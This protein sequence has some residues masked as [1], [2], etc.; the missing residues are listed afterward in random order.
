[1][2]TERVAIQKDSDLTI[3]DDVM[4]EQGKKLKEEVFYKGHRGR[5]GKEIV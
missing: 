4:G 1:M 2:E 3:D 5:R